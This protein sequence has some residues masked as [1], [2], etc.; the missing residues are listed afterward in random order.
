MM[1]MTVRQFLAMLKM[2]DGE[3][4]Q[5]EYKTLRGQ[6]INGDIDGAT[7]GLERLLRRR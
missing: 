5:Q 1:T 3:L 4:T 2:H 6:A 7:K